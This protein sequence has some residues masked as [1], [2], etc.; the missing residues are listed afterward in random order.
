MDSFTVLLRGKNDL[1][2]DFEPAAPTIFA[3]CFVVDINEAGGLIKV[4]M[5]DYDRR[6]PR[7]TSADINILR[8]GRRWDK[9]AWPR[10]GTA[11]QVRGTIHSQNDI[12]SIFSI[13][14]DAIGFLPISLAA[15]TSGTPSPKKRKFA[16]KVS[17]V[18]DPTPL[19]PNDE[20]FRP[21]PSEPATLTPAA[22]PSTSKGKSRSR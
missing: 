8:V 14:P 22:A 19:P 1:P 7:R 21:P 18:S 16:R 5:I 2:D 10:V 20:E 4:R 13:Q 9:T 12:T 15:D 17:S 6:V 3:I 11:I